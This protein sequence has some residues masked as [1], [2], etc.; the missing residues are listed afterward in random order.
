M[1]GNYPLFIHCLKFIFIT[2]LIV[3]SRQQSGHEGVK[4]DIMCLSSHCTKQT[5]RITMKRK[6]M[7]L[8]TL[9]LVMLVIRSSGMSYQRDTTVILDIS[10]LLNLYYLDNNVSQVNH[11]L[12]DYKFEY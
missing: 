5:P 1:S 8:F 7:M 2:A 9:L 4:F 12:K 11:I 6:V 3:E 10:V